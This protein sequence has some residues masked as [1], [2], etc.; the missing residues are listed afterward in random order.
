[1]TTSPTLVVNEAGTNNDDQDNNPSDGSA[2]LFEN[3][4]Y[5]FECSFPAN[6]VDPVPSIR[7]DLYKSDMTRIHTE[8]DSGETN[9]DC[10]SP[11]VSQMYELTANRVTFADLQN[12]FLVCTAY[13]PNVPLAA[14]NLDPF[15]NT[16]LYK[17]RINFVIWSKYVTYN[18]HQ[19]TQKLYYNLSTGS[20]H[21]LTILMMRNSHLAI[22]FINIYNQNLH[23]IC[24]FVFYFVSDR[25]LLFF[26]SVIYDPFFYNYVNLHT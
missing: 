24:I 6:T 2:T 16:N 12:G 14:T 19:I 9:A 18:F 25:G 13:T 3:M 5:F 7:W 22:N 11:A 21:S 23:I 10:S 26:F 4:N 17:D 15:V 1:M 20:A 8:T